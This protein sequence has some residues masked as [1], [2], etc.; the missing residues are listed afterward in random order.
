MVS[1]RSL[2]L[3]MAGLGFTAGVLAQ[4]RPAPPTSN[5]KAI[6]IANRTLEAMGGEA[7]WNNTR[8]LRFT[9]AVDREGKT[10]ASRDPHLGQVDRPLPPGR[11]GQGGQALRGPH[12]RQHQGGQGGEGRQSRSP[13]EEPEKILETAYA[14]G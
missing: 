4:S 7:A 10:V 6:D 8:Y 1:T 14:R 9:F 2:M 13:G 12:E 5:P 11:D 3:L